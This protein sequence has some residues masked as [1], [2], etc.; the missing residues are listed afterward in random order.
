MHLLSFYGINMVYPAHVSNQKFKNHMD[1]LMITD[2]NKSHFVY[3]R[4]FNRSMCN[5]TKNKNKKHFCRYCLQCLSSEKVLQEN[6]ETCLKI[7]GKQSVKLKSGLIR[8]QNN[9]K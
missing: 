2:E 4:Y 7:N 6:E 8:S 3:I 1:L 5:K 9:F